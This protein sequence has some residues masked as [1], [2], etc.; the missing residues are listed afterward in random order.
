MMVFVIM[1]TQVGGLGVA[2]NVDMH[3]IMLYV[4][5]VVTPMSS[6][7]CI[8]PTMTYG[9][10]YMTCPSMDGHLISHTLHV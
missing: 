5:H 10:M 6:S 4:R 9:D 2:M 3:F 7:S 8:S 1:C